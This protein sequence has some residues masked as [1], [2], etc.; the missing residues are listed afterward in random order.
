[1]DENDRTTVERFE[2]FAK[3]AAVERCND[4]LVSRKFIRFFVKL[5]TSTRAFQDQHR[6]NL[7]IVLLPK[8]STKY[9]GIIFQ[10]EWNG[11]KVTTAIKKATV[12]WIFFF[13]FFFS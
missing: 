2:L 4:K 11:P 13:F 3:M 8:M 6:L 5:E 10:I 12:D 9:R 7:W 1:M